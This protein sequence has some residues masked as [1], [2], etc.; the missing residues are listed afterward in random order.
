MVLSVIDTINLFFRV[1]DELLFTGQA[2]QDG[3]YGEVKA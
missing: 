1:N 3:K 2:E